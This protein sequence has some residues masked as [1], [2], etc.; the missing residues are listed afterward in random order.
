MPIL[1]I[2]VV[3]AD[4]LADDLA[5]RLAEMA[6]EVFGSPPG[7]TWVRL[8]SLPPHQYAENCTLQPEGH[9]AVFV[10]VLKAQPPSGAALA[11]E[12]R[13]LAEGVARVC[14]RSVENVHVLYEPGAQGRIAFGGCLNE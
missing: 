14:G 5:Q 9:R 1:E 10:A 4:A 8:R 11:S 3:T 7:R 6:G 2:E 13:S 12:A